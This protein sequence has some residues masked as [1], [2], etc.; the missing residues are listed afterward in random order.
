MAAAADGGAALARRLRSRGNPAGTCPAGPG[1]A[2][3][4]AANNATA[5]DRATG[6]THGSPGPN[7]DPGNGYHATTATDRPATHGHGSA[8]T[9]AHPGDGHHA[10]ASTHRATGAHC[11]AADGDQSSGADGI[12]V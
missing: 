10:A 7:T 12:A 2:A 6:C 11:P 1:D 4:A 8:A 5:T 9:D 3:G